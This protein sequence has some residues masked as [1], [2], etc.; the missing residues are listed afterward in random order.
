MK[1]SYPRH[2]ESQPFTNFQKDVEDILRP[3]STEA[4]AALA[5]SLGEAESQANRR[6]RGTWR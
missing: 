4:S 1:C 3:P 5:M 2:G 6:A